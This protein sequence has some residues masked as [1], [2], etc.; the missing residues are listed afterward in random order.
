MIKIIK[1]GKKSKVMHLKYLDARIVVANLKQTN[2][3]IQGY[4]VFLTIFIYDQNAQHAEE[5][6]L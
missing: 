6:Y 2:L 1:E 3:I 5:L 4:S